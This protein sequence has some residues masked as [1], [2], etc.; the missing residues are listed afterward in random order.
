MTHTAIPFEEP[1]QTHANY[2]ISYFTF[3]KDIEIQKQKKP[4]IKLES[5]PFLKPISDEV[6]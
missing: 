1:F 4:N 6:I 3:Q 5:F 2:S